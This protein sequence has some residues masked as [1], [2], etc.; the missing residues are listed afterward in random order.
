M[1]FKKKL[2]INVLSRAE[3]FSRHYW[4]V[5]AAFFLLLLVVAFAPKS[6]AAG[7]ATPAPGPSSASV[8]GY[9]WVAGQGP[10]VLKMSQIS[11]AENRACGR[12]DYEACVGPATKGGSPSLVVKCFIPRNTT[13]CPGEISRTKNCFVASSTPPSAFVPN[14]DYRLP[15]NNNLPS[16]CHCG[17]YGRRDHIRNTATQCQTEMNARIAAAGRA[18][19][20]SDRTRLNHPACETW[21]AANASF[22]NKPAGCNA[23][24]APV[25]IP[26]AVCE[27]PCPIA[28]EEMRLVNGQCV[29]VG[30]SGVPSEVPAGQLDCGPGYVNSGSSCEP[31]P[32]AMNCMPGFHFNGTNCVE[33]SSDD[34][35]ALAV[36]CTA[37]CCG[38][39]C[40]NS[41]GGN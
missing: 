24:A 14:C 35:A 33:D 41:C 28:N 26:G 1:S 8:E 32:H 39:N 29:C 22:A 25:V 13:E 11:D 19:C 36:G 34:A 2:R 38:P 30:A 37:G 9:Q 23:V 17:L 31:D 21:C 3:D 4:Q 6:W 10:R 15:E 12:Q 40:C 27:R 16:G 7:P 18:A 5:I 20:P